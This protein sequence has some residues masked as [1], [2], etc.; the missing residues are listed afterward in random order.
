[1]K[2]TIVAVL[3]VLVYLPVFCAEP[4]LDGN[5]AIVIDY[6]GKSLTQQQLQN[7]IENAKNNIISESN[8]QFVSYTPKLSQ[9]QT[10]LINKALSKYT[11]EKD[12]A[13][14]IVIG[15][16][17]GFVTTQTYFFVVT[18]DQNYQWKKVSGLE[19]APKLR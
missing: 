19:F 3:L 14:I 18:I 12:E 2:R 15:T 10:Y 8:L 16:F 11:L 13:Y 17:F 4:F 1:M 6:W 7:G 5:E 9:R